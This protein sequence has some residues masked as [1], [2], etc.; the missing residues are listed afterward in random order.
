M[1]QHGGLAGQGAQ[2]FPEDLGDL[3]FPVREVL[4]PVEDPQDDVAEAGEGDAAT[5]LSF[6]GAESTDSS[7]P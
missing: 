5:P 1:G 3:A 7:S 4:L 2:A 6:Y